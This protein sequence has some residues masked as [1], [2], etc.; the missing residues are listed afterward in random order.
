MKFLGVV[1]HYGVRYGFAP[2]TGIF[3]SLSGT[4]WTC[5]TSRAAF[6]T[7]VRV[8]ICALFANSPPPDLVVPVVVPLWSNVECFSIT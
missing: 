3:N 5:N 2:A 7:S 8:S 4:R 1:P 6:P